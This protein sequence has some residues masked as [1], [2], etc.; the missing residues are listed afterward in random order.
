MRD[1]LLWYAIMIFVDLVGRRTEESSIS[2]YKIVL[3]NL[4]AP[5]TVLNDT[6]EWVSDLML[7]PPRAE[8]VMI[9]TLAL[10]QLL[11]VR[12]GMYLP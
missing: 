1:V 5:M 12:N 11:L 9:C 6:T 3:N 7:Y 8:Q 2:L 10:Q 4:W